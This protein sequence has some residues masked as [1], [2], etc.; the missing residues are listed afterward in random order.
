MVDLVVSIGRKLERN[1]K[2]SALRGRSD[3]QLPVALQIAEAL[4]FVEGPSDFWGSV[5]LL[6]AS[7]NARTPDCF[8]LSDSWD[9]SGWY[10]PSDCW[11][12]FRLLRAPQIARVPWISV[13]PQI[14]GGPQIDGAPQIVGAL[15]IAGGPRG[16]LIA[17][18][19]LNTTS[20]SHAK[21]PEIWS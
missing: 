6:R 15:Q 9:P 19:T 1:D 7:Q 16:L 8:G 21:T 4:Q 5:R 10:G 20:S 12:P 14:A 13:A 11:K 18:W 3:P 2:T 17:E